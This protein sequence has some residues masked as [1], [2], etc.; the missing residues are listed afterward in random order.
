MSQCQ[1][2]S[3]NYDFAVLFRAF[4]LITVL[5][6]SF[7]KKAARPTNIFFWGKIITPEV[8]FGI[9]PRLGRQVQTNQD[10]YPYSK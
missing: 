4:I 10:S 5:I 2:P 7:R 6:F 3:V 9:E 1:Y 8:V